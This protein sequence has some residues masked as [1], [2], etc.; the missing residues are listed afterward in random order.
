MIRPKSE[1]EKEFVDHLLSVGIK[2][3]AEMDEVD[4]KQNVHTYYE[5]RLNNGELRYWKDMS[6]ENLKRLG[7]ESE[8]E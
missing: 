8:G 4:K 7:I 3:Y 1:C 5:F 6:S 2:A